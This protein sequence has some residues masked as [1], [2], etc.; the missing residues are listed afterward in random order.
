MVVETFKLHF[1][2]D[3]EPQESFK[4]GNKVG[5]LPGVSEPLRDRGSSMKCFRIQK[6]KNK[7]Y[8]FFLHLVFYS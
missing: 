3:T 7:L 4:R 2:A 8:S 6:I 1:V 5:I